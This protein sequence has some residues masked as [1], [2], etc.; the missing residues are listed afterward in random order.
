MSII[1]VWIAIWL[2]F[3]GDKQIAGQFDFYFSALIRFSVV[4]D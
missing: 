4:E 1:V 2:R 3:L